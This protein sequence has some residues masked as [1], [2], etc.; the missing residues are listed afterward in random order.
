MAPRIQI[1]VNPPDPRHPCS[2]N[3]TSDLTISIIKET[4]GWLALSKPADMQVERNPFGPSVE[5]LAYAHLEKQKRRPFVGIVHRLD[6]VTTGAVIVAKKKSTL[7]QLNELFRLREVRKTYLAMVEKAPAQ[8]EAKLIHWLKK[9]LREKRAQVVD[10]ATPKAVECTLSYRLL[11]VGERGRALLEI[12]P[13]TGKY[14]QIRA[15]MAAI[16]SPI[17]GDT[18]YGARE[19]YRPHHIMLHAW[20]LEFDDPASGERVLLE[21]GAPEWVDGLMG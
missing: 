1:C 11:Q 12:R 8:P 18:H 9:G 7:K 3:H 5:S 2:I 17:V 19:E 16:G 4:P 20:K 21:A 13:L 15:Q 6:R 14:H 10:Q